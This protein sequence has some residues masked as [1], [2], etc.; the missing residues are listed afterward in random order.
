APELGSYLSQEYEAP[1]GEIEEI[2]AGIW[3]ELLRVERV[4][5]HDNFFEL[6]GH[7]LLAVQLMSRIRQGLGREIALHQLFEHPTVGT[8]A[9]QLMSID[10]IAIT[11]I[12]RADRT[13]ALP[14][15]WPQQ[16]LWF[17]EQMEE[18][19]TAYNMRS[20][21]RMVGELD[22]AALQA[23]LD[24]LIERHEVLRTVFTHDDGNAVQRIQDPCRFD[25]AQIDLNDL[26][27]T[28]REEQVWRHAA[29]EVGTPFNLATG[30]L[31][32]GRL[33]R[34]GEQE[35]VL[36]LTMHHIVSD[37]WSMGILRRELAALYAAYKEGQANPL[38]PLPLQYA[39]YSVWQRQWLQ[40]DLLQSQLDY[41]KAHLAGAPALLELPTDRV[42]PLQQNYRGAR[43]AFVIDTELTLKLRKLAR[44]HHATMFMTIYTA[45]VILLSR[46]SGQDDVVIGT[47]VANRLRT[48]VESLI[49]F[50]VNTLA[51]RAKLDG[52]PT[53]YGLLQQV[54]AMMLDAHSHQDVP[55]E[56]VVDVVQPPRSL[57]HSPIFQVMLVLHNTPEGEFSLPGL[58]LMP[59]DMP[60]DTETSDL[61][62]ALQESGDRISGAFSYASALFDQTTIERWVG[63][64]KTVLGAMVQDAEQRVKAIALLDEEERLGV[65]RGFNATRADYPAGKPVH[66]WIEEQVE[67][68]PEAVALVYGEATL[69]YAELNRRA[70]QLAHHL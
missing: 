65:L 37:G 15:S 32:R 18:G 12:G 55:F 25:I 13:Q 60:H 30:H 21:L 42:R 10:S 6:G 43:A 44:E 61:T 14:L 54:K 27:A 69:S 66:A 41:W 68:N 23:A 48:E 56:Q 53:V 50:F 70:N 22:R 28:E 3:K 45:F 36:L 67:R 57:S 58:K 62:L 52:N 31:I 2:L 47:P 8:L 19:D 24:T 33:L 16:A 34:V 11:A 4:G 17:I 1:Q 29:E 64:F 63:H 40:G 51:L 26:P 9:R 20:A 59:Q 38:A 5:R 39:D 35:H 7:S 46:L 49:G